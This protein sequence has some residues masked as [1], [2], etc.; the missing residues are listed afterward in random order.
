MNT[1]ANTDK[2]IEAAARAEV[3]QLRKNITPKIKKAQELCR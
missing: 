2:K 3:E 1:M